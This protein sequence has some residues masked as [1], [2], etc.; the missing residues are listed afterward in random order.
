MRV[1]ELESTR[2]YQYWRDDLRLTSELGIRV[3]R[4]GVPYYKVN[5]GP[6]VYDWSFLDEVLRE[7]QRLG[8]EPILDLCHFGMPSWLG[9]S[10][11]NPDF[12][13][14]FA[15][16][17]RVVAERYP[18]IRLY[19]PVNEMY[20]CAKFSA[21]LGWWNEREKSDRAYLTATRNLAKASRLGMREIMTATPQA[22][23]IQSEA[24]EQTH[25][26]CG[27]EDNRKRVEWDNQLRFLALDLLY[28]HQVRA[29][30]HAWL[31][32]NGM[33]REEYRWFMSD[34][35]ASRCV[36]GNDYYAGNERILQHDGS[37]SQQGEVFGWYLVTR[38]Y[39]DRYRKPLMHTETNNSGAG[40]AV[41]WLWKQWQNILF[42]RAK[43]VPVLGFTWFSLT[44]QVDWDTQ[45]RE[46][47]GTVNPW[48]LY[49][50]DR[51]IRPVG[52][53]YRNLIQEFSWLP[54]VPNGDF[55][56]VT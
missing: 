26:V 22:V 15:A 42:M 19:T 6:G 52:E 11:Q 27:C 1:D 36:M 4:Y 17:A 3:L 56:D 49:D 7:M 14:A 31:L 50:L 25:T 38:Q 47:N 43:G 23:F 32:D 35:L 54:V 44:D 20:I 51:K 13:T 37:V 39:Y 18:W 5:T 28:G 8:I 21:Q 16:Y 34:G 2:H 9:N 41:E 53:A 12:P 29:D 10:F 24:S 45:L 33:S 48:G 55:F 30:V 40:D 46:P